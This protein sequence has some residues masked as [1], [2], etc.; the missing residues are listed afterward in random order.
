MN[1][2]YVIPYVNVTVLQVVT[3]LVVLVAGLFAVRIVV[4][5]FKRQMRRTRLHDVLVEF[6]ARFLSILL[7]ILVLLLVLVSLG[8]T[9]GSLLVSISA[10][11]GLVLGFGMQDTVNNIASGTWIAALGPIDIGE[12]VEINGK[13]GKV[14]A[15]GIMATELLTPDNVLITIPNGEVWGTSIVNYSREPIR[16]V[17]VDVGIAYGEDIGKAVQVATEFMKNDGRVL[18]DPEPSVFVKELANSSINLSLRPWSAGDDYWAV[19][20]DMTKGIYEAL[21]AAGIEIPFPQ[22]DVHMKGQ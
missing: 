16:R 5:V 6:L 1:W 9:V 13:R 22:V 11:I 20:N 2:D 15:V 3:A 14:R 10:V 4:G 19:K 17:D 12:A 8:V 18:S 7:Y 21:G